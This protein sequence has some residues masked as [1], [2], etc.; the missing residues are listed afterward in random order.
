MNGKDIT[1]AYFQLGKHPG[2]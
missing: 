1:S 2:I